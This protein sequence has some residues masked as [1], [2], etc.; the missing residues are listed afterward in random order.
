MDVRDACAALSLG[1]RI[2]LMFDNFVEHCPGP[3]RPDGTAI[4]FPFTQGDIA[5]LFDVSRQSIH[6]E[7]SRLRALGVLDKRDGVWVIADRQKL[8]SHV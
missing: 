4:A 6:R 1:Q 7:I 2:A 5:A 8:S 3:A